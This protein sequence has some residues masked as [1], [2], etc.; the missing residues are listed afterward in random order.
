MG[1]SHC[2]SPEIKLQTHSLSF[3]SLLNPSSKAGL[4]TLS[5]HLV[6]ILQGLIVGDGDGVSKQGVGEPQK[7]F[8]FSA[9]V[10]AGW[11][12]YL[13]LAVARLFS[14]SC[15]SSLRKTLEGVAP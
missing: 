2:I 1:V 10:L 9:S 13:F 8:L 15:L 4:Q 12:L 6:T 7:N 14:I 11:Q 3:S 5:S